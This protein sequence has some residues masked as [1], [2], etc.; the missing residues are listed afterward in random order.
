MNFTT[1]APIVPISSINSIAPLDSLANL[2]GREGVSQKRPE[3][4]QF[5]VDAIKQVDGLQKNAE[6]A[7]VQLALGQG[8][9]L[10]SA[11]VALE[12]A[13][14]SLTLMVSARD[15]AIDAYNQIARMQI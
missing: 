1:I 13:S 15:K 6:V 7:S 11:M 10:S 4:A 14:L 2:D 5:L 12:K 9:D 3:F 8:D